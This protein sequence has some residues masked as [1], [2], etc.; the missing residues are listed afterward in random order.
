MNTENQTLDNTMRQKYFLVS[1]KWTM[2]VVL[3]A[4]LAYAGA[5]LWSEFVFSVSVGTSQVGQKKSAEIMKKNVCAKNDDMGKKFKVQEKYYPDARNPLFLDKN[6]RFGI[7]DDFLLEY[8]GCIAAHIVAAEQSIKG[9]T[10]YYFDRATNKPT[11][12]VTID[13]VK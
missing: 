1:K 8:P 2:I 3:L 7:Y 11:V 5:V 9:E 13:S 6:Y 10:M 4:L 12:K